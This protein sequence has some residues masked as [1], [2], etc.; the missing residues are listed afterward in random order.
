MRPDPPETTRET[1]HARTSKVPKP[2]WLRVPFPR[3]STYE[4]IKRIVRENGLHTVCQAAACPNLGECWSHGTATFMILGDVCTRNCSFCGV[5]SGMPGTLER[6]E[7]I[8][9]AHAAAAMG[10]KH[11]V[12]TSV[13]RDD[14][15]DGGASIFSETIRQVRKENPDARTEVLIPDFKGDDGALRHVLDS[16]VEIVAHNVETVP[17]LYSSLRPQAGYARSVHLIHRL[18]QLH[19]GVVTKSGFMVGLGETWKELTEVMKDLF[20]VGCDVLTIGQYLRPGKDH[21]PVIR[22]YLPTE[23]ESLKEAARDIGFREVM[24]GPLVRSSYRADQL[25]SMLHRVNVT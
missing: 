7:P 24:S 6:D 10:V 1:N 20:H 12:V 17:R 5:P 21:H 8:R 16:P 13:T 23:F 14:L 11:V 25:G 22:Y 18:K 19:P 9:V 2:S 15:P 4:R 3:G